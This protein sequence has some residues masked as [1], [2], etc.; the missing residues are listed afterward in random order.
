VQ[1][2]VP[3]RVG[4]RPALDFLNTVDPRHS[5]PRREYL[6]DYAALLAVAD[7][8]AT[9]LPAPV[10]VLQALAVADPAAA[11]AAHRTAVELRE[12]LYAVFAAALTRQPGPT[13]DLAVVNAQLCRATEH[14]LLLPDPDGGVRDGWVDQEQ[15]DSPLWPVLIDAW[16]VLT[17]QLIAR[18]R[19]CPGEQQTCGWLFLDTSRSGT[20]RWCDMRTCGNRAKVRSHYTRKQDDRA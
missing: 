20:R 6:T 2:P 12:S 1:L 17:T 15:L 9:A 7:G 19:E 10:S 5:E 3:D 14:H 18:V 4:G 13:A 11:E 16:D 8:L